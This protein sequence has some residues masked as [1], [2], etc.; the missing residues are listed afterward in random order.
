MMDNF[1]VNHHAVHVRNFGF[2][3]LPLDLILDTAHGDVSRMSNLDGGRTRC[4]QHIDGDDIVLSITV[5]ALVG[6]TC[7]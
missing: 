7:R 1:H 4:A 2:S 5:A 6:G 3:D